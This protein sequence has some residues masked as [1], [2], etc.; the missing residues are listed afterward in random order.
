M[1]FYALKDECLSHDRLVSLMLKWNTILSLKAMQV[2]IHSLRPFMDSITFLC[3]FIQLLL[4]LDH[5]IGT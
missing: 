5:D 2:L 3:S 1:P 4:G